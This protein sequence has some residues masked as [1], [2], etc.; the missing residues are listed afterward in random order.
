M[1]FT[2]KFKSLVENAEVENQDSDFKSSRH[3]GQ[4]RVSG[5]AIYK[6][7][8]TYLPFSAVTEIVHDKTAVHVSG[9]CA[10]GVPV[11]RLMFIC[12]NVK[13]PFIFDGFKDIDKMKEIEAIS[14]ML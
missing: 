11:D 9:C 2:K 8:G 5:K 6:A 10:G 14:G 3:I 13:F 12:G 7:D 1:L 4:Y